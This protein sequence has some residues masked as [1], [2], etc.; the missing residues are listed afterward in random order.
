MEPQAGA[1]LREHA[2]LDG[3]DPRCLRRGDERRGAGGIAGGYL[4]ARLQP[5]LPEKALRLLLAALAITLAA[6]YLSQALR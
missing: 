4:G 5:R 3:P 1:V 2:T 6:L